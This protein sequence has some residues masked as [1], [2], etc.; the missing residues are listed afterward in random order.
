MVITIVIALLLNINGNYIA[1]WTNV[2]FF[3]VGK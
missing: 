2:F 1:E 3:L